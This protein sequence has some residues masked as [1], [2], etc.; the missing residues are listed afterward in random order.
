MVYLNEVLAQDGTG[1]ISLALMIV[2]HAAHLLCLYGLVA[3]LE[4]SKNLSVILY[5]EYFP[6]AHRMLC[7]LMF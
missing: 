4:F 5:S 3:H 1:Q 7:L 2:N 6:C